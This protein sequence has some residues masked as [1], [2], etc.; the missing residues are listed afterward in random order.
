MVELPL[1]VVD[2]QRAGP[3]TG[4]PTK[5]EQAD[6]LQVLWGRN[7]DSP[8][9]VL[10][11]A[12]PGDCFETI[13]EAA[14]IAVKYMT[15]VIFLSDGY[16]G[17]GAEP[18]KIP[19]LKALK[20]FEFGFGLDKDSYKPYLR[21]PETGAR[22]WAVPG[23][24]GL[25]HRI[26]GIEKEAVTGKINYEAANHQKMTDERHKKVANV[27]KE[28]PPSK[29]SGDQEGELLVISWGGTF[30]AVLTAVEEALKVKR[31]IGHLHLR[32]INPLPSDLKEIMGRYKHVLVPEL[33]NG[34]LAY[35]LRGI[36]GMPVQSVAQVSGRMFSVSELVT[37]FLSYIK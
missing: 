26:T 16:L 36:F 28:I 35:H 4:M 9:P 10:A 21:N 32:F 3:S 8:M 19:D 33:N 6:L 12:T 11:A 27:A 20:P 34:Q 23:T 31:G 18:W 15:P 24:P 7:G 1:L 25:E 37:K 13:Y 30:G 2:V 29:V 14:R 22:P 17:N 5:T